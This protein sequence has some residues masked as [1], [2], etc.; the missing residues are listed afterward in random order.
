MAFIR[1]SRLGA[2]GLC[3][4]PRRHH[5]RGLAAELDDR[6]AAEEATTLLGLS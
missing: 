1:T 3:Q 2:R 6:L 5:Q 4:P